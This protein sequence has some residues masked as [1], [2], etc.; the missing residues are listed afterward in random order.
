M[1]IMVTGTNGFVGSKLMFDLE[2]QRHNIIGIDISERCDDIAHPKTLIGDIRKI[3]DLN[4]VHDAFV[5]SNRAGIEMIIHCA[6]AKHDFGVSHKEYYSHNKI[7]T[8]VLLDFAGQHK[9]NK[10]VY[11][12]T[13]GVYGHPTECT[14]ENGIYNPDH[15]YG[16]SKLAGE[17]LCL[18]WQ[19]ES[20]DH[21]LLVLRPTV[22]YGAYNYA[23]MYKMMDMMHR[24]P[25]ITIGDGNYIKSIVSRANVIDMT[26][27]AMGKMKPGL[28]DYNCVDKP[29][30]TVRRLM[31]II[32]ANPAFKIPRIQVPVSFAVFIGR[33]FDIPA[34]LFKIDL[35]V[36]SDRMKK[37]ATAT[38]FASEKIR[39][40]G[41]VQKHSIE[42]EILKM[43]SWY[44]ELKKK[45]R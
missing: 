16:A 29:Y 30:I 36:N 37:F 6:A 44:L 1:N 32:A 4:R 42:D 22:I 26:I 3:D 18:E 45:S 24:K 12:S 38:H 27:F 19:K 31:E 17:L 25:W 8:K 43:T 9:I 23:N 40:N 11:F 13:V 10:I 2:A 41:Y 5:E 15:P 14:D 28:L 35:P 39:D 21:W 7:G 33:L 34:R 20:A